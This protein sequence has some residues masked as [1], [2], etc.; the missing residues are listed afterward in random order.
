MSFQLNFPS[1]N[2]FC[3]DWLVEVGFGFKKRGRVSFPIYGISKITLKVV[4][5]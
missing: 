1:D 3:L 5:F 2:V 4:V